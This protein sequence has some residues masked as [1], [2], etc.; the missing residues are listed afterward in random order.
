MSV[1]VPADRPHRGPP[2]RRFSMFGSPRRAAAL[3]GLFAAAAAVG[4]V[5]PDRPVAAQPAAFSPLALVPADAAV[6]V[7]LDAAKVW[8]GPIAKS[9]RDADPKTFGDIT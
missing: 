2:P 3:A 9:L 7:H 8:G 5:R 1:A 6:F 4:L